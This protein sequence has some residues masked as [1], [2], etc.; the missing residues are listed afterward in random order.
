MSILRKTAHASHIEILTGRGPVTFEPATETDPQARTVR[1]VPGVVH[2]TV[3]HS[4]QGRHVVVTADVNTADLA[5]GRFPS[6]TPDRLAVATT[7][8]QAWEGAATL[9][10]TY[11]P[12]MRGLA[13]RAAARTE[14]DRCHETTALVASRLVDALERAYLHLQWVEALDAAATTPADQLGETGKVSA[15][16]VD[17]TGVLTRLAVD[18]IGVVAGNVA[19]DE[20]AEQHP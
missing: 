7:V 6:N 16:G 5:S 18:T 17:A 20:H 11:E 15:V 14:R 2:V 4:H 12:T 3:P 19:A 10:A 13:L 1:V 9:Y 8:T